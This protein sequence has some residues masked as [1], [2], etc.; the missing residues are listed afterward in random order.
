MRII[1]FHFYY[2]LVGGVRVNCEI[3]NEGTKKKKVTKLNKLL[4][5]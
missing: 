1:P 3:A 4:N 2:S 5:K